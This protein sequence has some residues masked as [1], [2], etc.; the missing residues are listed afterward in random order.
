MKLNL[1]KIKNLRLLWTF[2]QNFI[3]STLLISLICAVLFYQ[4]GLPALS[5]VIWLKTATLGITWYYI[6][7]YKKS[8]FFYYFNLGLSKKTL[9]IGTLGFDFLLF[10]LFLLTASR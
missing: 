6:T 9:W 1:L 2:Y 5:A 10:S 4:Y 3:F 8:E 7:N